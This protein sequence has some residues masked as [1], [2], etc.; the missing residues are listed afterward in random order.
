MLQAAKEFTAPTI[1]NSLESLKLFQQ[2]IQIA[3]PQNLGT[4]HCEF[5]TW[6]SCPINFSFCAPAELWGGSSLSSCRVSLS[7]E[8]PGKERGPLDKPGNIPANSTIFL[9]ELHNHV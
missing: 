5:L 1:I 8:S 9:E 4:E 3:S 6:G 2:I 7:A